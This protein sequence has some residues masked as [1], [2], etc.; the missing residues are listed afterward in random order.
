MYIRTV[1]INAFGF[2]VEYTR[3]HTQQDK[4]YFGGVSLT[5]FTYVQYVYVYT[6]HIGKSCVLCVCVCGKM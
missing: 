6:V 2:T 3:L 1:G 5:N 4:R